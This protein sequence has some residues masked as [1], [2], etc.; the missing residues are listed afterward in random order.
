MIRF[1]G[2]LALFRR[3]GTELLF[4]LEQL[5]CFV[6]ASKRIVRLLRVH[7]V[8]FSFPALPSLPPFYI[9]SKETCLDNALLRERERE[10]DGV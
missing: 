4:Q 9:I 1:C 6:A 10:N 7:P 2:R 3:Q 8:G 5:L